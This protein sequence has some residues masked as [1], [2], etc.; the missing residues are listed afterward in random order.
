VSLPCLE[1]FVRVTSSAD[2]PLAGN[3]VRSAVEGSL[4]AEEL[5]PRRPGDA[6]VSTLAQGAGALTDC[7]SVCNVVFDLTDNESLARLV[8]GALEPVGQILVV[9][10][11]A[12][13]ARSVARRGVRGLVAQL[14]AGRPRSLAKLSQAVDGAN[15]RTSE[16]I[17]RRAE[18]VGALFGSVANA[19]IWSIAT[20]TILG[21]VGINLAPLIAGAGIVG[22]ALGFG[23]QDLVK[24]FLSG[25]SIL[26]E[27][28]YG[29]GDVVDVGEAT[30]V[31]EGIS[32]RS[33]RIRDV[34]GQLWHVPNGEIRRV[35]NASQEWA[36]AL[37]DVSVAY[38]A[39]IDHAVAVIEGAGVELH[40]DP[41]WSPVLLEAP[42]VWGVEE[43]GGDRVLLRM[44]I[45]T[46]PGEQFKVM[47]ALR[48][49]V[50][51]A[52]DKAGIEMPFAQRT[53]WLRA[54]QSDVAD[55]LTPGSGAP[56][57]ASAP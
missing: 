1:C 13:I 29:V 46:L 3:V 53:V 28:Q 38:G 31:V 43:L 49:R 35:A 39:D 7:G 26:M 51:Y 15:A 11:L 33:T 20:L 22:V 41:A 57:E 42:E 32:L 17:E 47:R 48:R 34:S 8:G 16:R 25:V 23:A 19:V 50:K 9:L 27:D 2:C 24:D 37:L 21:A 56:T 30:G 55:D 14:R 44:V 10:V 12:V 54:D 5:D 4:L 36:R 40:S 6:S 18:S 52:L 45:K